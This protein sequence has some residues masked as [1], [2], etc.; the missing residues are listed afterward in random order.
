MLTDMHI[1]VIGGD[2]RQ[3]E[4]IRK[5][6]ELDAKLSL[7]GFDQLDHGFTGASKEHMHEL[8]FASLDA[9]VLPVAG[10]NTEGGIDT[11]F[12]KRESSAD[13]RTN[14]KNTAA[15]HYIFWD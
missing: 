13:K 12:F 7:V 10:T 2:A 5:L 9:V 1:A 4:V 3:L 15:F 11:I 14:R 8:D 6:I